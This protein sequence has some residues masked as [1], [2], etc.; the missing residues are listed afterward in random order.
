MRR[1]VEPTCLAIV[2]AAQLALFTRLLST[3][4]D[5]DEGVYLLALDGLRSGQ[6]LGS[7]I[8]TAQPPVFYR[9]LQVV[10]F[11]LGDTPE[12]VRLGIALLAL[13]G[14]IASWYL[15]RSITG[16]AAGLLA[17]AFLT[18]SQPLPLFA[19]RIHADLPS[20]W[21]VLIALA[22]GALAVRHNA[23]AAAA[24]AG[25]VLALATKPSAIIALPVL[26][27]LLATGERA[28]RRR[29]LWATGG[30]AVAAAVV[31]GSHAGAL[32]AIW[33]GVVTYHRRA[34]STPDVIDRWY[35]IHE[36][37]QVKT[38]I[39]W[40]LALGAVAFSIRVARRRVAAA[41]IALWV[42]A[43]LAF[44]VLATYS[45]LHY[46]HLVALP[47]PLALA[48]ATSIGGVAAAA[49]DRARTIA[50]VV[51]AAV[52]AAAYLQQWRRVLIADEPQSPVEVAV[53]RKLERVTKPG[54]LVVSDLPVSAVLARRVSPGPLVDIAFLRFE[55]GSLTDARVLRVI[56]ES[57]V[58]AVV[59]GRALLRHPNVV[60]GV[61]E[62]FARSVRV[63]GATVAYGRRAACA[64]GS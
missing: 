18:I 9:L 28:V 41:E 46:N 39:F 27:V 5:F 16:P 8:F 48:S 52:V 38:P 54:D 14:T 36:L 37:F 12:H 13:G 56:D 35:S 29:L 17:A 43:G 32:R 40:L 2:L 58:E 30:A 1:L 21:L 61:R 34:D 33:D 25:A 50:L 19:S 31:L 10:A 24:G 26:G 62:R 63:D 15:I 57:C 6:K 7:E 20:L 11:V 47:V 55:T 60:A 49:P 3:A 22:L 42:W 45:P 59:V 23:V 53:A 64:R 51:L 44:V 4:L